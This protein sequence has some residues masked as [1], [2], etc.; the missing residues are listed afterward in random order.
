MIS[1]CVRKASAFD[2]FHSVSTHYETKIKQGERA[3]C[4]KSHLLVPAGGT[5]L[6]GRHKTSSVPVVVAQR[7]H[8]FP[9]PQLILSFTFRRYTP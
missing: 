4:R 5:D 9:P 2:N 7:N 1:V 6:L 3:R 8:V